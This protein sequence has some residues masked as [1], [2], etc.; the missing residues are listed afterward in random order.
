MS[1]LRRVIVRGMRELAWFTGFATYEAR[2]SGVRWVMMLHGVGTDGLSADVLAENL[3]WLQRNFRIVKLG[4]MVESLESGRAPD[5]RG[6]IA[7]TF[8]DGLRN[9]ALQA[10]PVLRSL[11]LPATIFVCPGLIDEGSWMWNH[12]ARAR[13]SR[14]SPE[15]LLRFADLVAGNQLSGRAVVE[16]MKFIPAERRREL[17]K[18]IQQATPDFVPTPDE[19]TS[20]DLMTWEELKGLDP[21]LITI[22]SHTVSHPILPELDEVELAFE[23]QASRE[24]LEERLGRQVDLFCY[25]NGASDVRAH[26]IVARVYRAAVLTREGR[27]GTAVDRFAIPRLALEGPCKDLAWRMLR[28]RS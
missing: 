26:R 5:A 17:H 1:A 16:A 9:Q 23:I 2:R 10:Y 11:G 14:L 8:D 13:L 24:M 28:C 27:V 22:G 21:E 25:P 7:L 6:E 18:Q 12:D 15:E 19:R 20:S 4:E 3:I